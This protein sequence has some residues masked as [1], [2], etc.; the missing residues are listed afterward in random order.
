MVKRNLRLTLILTTAGILIVL[1]ALSMPSVAYA[2]DPVPAPDNGNCVTC[3]EDLYLLHDTGNWFCL[4]ESPMTCVDC[5]GG[6]PNTLDKELAHAN[7]AT[8][9][10]LNE[11]VTKCQQCHPDKCDERVEFFDQTAGISRILVAI[12]HAPSYSTEY[13][14]IKPVEEPQQV[15]KNLLIFWE[16][17]PLVVVSGLAL[18]I[19]LTLR[20]RHA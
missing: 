13:A 18:A 14:S 12:P 2:D 5:H 4:K 16:V 9:P 3:H 1:T 8:H 19:Y 11:D 7:R 17:I 10:I 15:P 6:D 20:K